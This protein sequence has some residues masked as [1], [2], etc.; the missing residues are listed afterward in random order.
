MRNLGHMHLQGL[1]ALLEDL[2]LLASL[3]LQ[4]LLQDD[5]LLMLSW[6]LLQLGEEH[7]V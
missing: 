4:D 7:L 6:F 2:C 3:F 1:Q 5:L